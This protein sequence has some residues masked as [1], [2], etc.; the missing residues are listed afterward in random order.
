MQVIE[1]QL[2]YML[3]GLLRTVIYIHTYHSAWKIY[4]C[5]TIGANA[6]DVLT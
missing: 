5:H 6:T 2:A 1:I 3:S 4:N